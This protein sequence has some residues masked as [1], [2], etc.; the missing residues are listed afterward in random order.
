MKT[1]ILTNEYNFTN[2]VQRNLDTLFNM[3]YDEKKKA[4]HRVAVFKIKHN[5]IIMKV[6]LAKIKSI[7]NNVE[8]YTLFYKK[9]INDDMSPLKIDYIHPFT[10]EVNNDC[11]IASLHRIENMSGTQIM[12]IMI[13]LNKL[14]NVKNV[15]LSDG[16]TVIIGDQKKDLSI[17]KMLET[18]KTYYMRF[19]FDFT[20][21][22]MVNY[23]YK[24]N[25]IDDLHKLV[26]KTIKKIRNITT[27]QIHDEYTN[28]TDM[29]NRVDDNNIDKLKI[30]FKG[31]PSIVPASLSK[32]YKSSV[33]KD[34]VEGLKAEAINVI[35]VISKFNHTYIY[36]I[37]VDLFN[38]RDERYIIL[39][40][41]LM[42]STRYIIK[43]EKHIIKRK[44]ITWFH[45][46]NV[47]LADY[48]YVLKL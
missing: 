42:S 12:D 23:I 32:I 26:N 14:L 44:Y 25:N 41:Y 37:L 2:N 30:Y 29:L 43:F 5:D 28:L 46:L 45:L 38:K 13:K 1:L 39:N 34:V 18:N 24:F 27:K 31:R 9:I 11:Y 7:T 19:G 22:G 16:S 35:D 20:L 10:L 36:E 48:Y 47:I 33:T 4:T 6:K 17:M 21:Y 40:D 3:M 15:Y 8:F